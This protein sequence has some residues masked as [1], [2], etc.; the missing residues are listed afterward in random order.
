VQITVAETVGLEG[1]AGYY[2]KAGARR[3]GAEPYVAASPRG[4]GSAFRTD[5]VRDEKLKVLRSLKY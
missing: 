2:D 4:D 1:R 5:A 3:H